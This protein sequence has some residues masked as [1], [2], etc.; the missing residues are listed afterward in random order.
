MRRRIEGATLVLPTELVS[1]DLTM[2]DGTIVQI[3]GTRGPVDEVINASGL[4]VL[5]G[6]I[7]DQV[8]FRD[9]GL[10]HKED[11]YS[12]SRACAAGGVTTFLEMPNT[13]PNTTSQAVLEAKLALASHKSMVN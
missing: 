1:A 11:L 9:P 3:G 6:L 10:T 8:H 7:D 12:A 5:P 2:H 13:V 4:H